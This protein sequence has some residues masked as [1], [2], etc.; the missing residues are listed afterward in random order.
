[1]KSLHQLD[2]LTKLQNG[3]LNGEGKASSEYDLRWLKKLVIEHIPESL[4]PHVYP[5]PEGGVQ[6]EWDFGPYRASLEIDLSKCIGEW[7]CLNLVTD[8]SKN[9]TFILTVPHCW[10]WLVTELHYMKRRSAQYEHRQ[11]HQ[12]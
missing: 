3:W 9:R 4:N 12:K 11:T 2:E 5:T 7:H 10:G 1:M 8:E 6:L